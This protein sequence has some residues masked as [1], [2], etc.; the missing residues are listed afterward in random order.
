MLVDK[1][2]NKSDLRKLSKLTLRQNTQ[3]LQVIRL[4]LS[5]I[6]KYQ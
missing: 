3:G 6:D 2:F 4:I 5:N 1:K